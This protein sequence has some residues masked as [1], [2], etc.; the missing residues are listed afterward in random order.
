LQDHFLKEVHEAIH[1]CQQ[2]LYTIAD[3]SAIPR[4]PVLEK[5]DEAFCEMPRENVRERLPKYNL[6][7]HSVFGDDV[8][9]PRVKDFL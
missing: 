3:T 8:G 5:R 9:L 2:E 4:V 7:T 1:V 6:Y